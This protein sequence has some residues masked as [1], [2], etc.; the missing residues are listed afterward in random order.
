MLRQ[1]DTPR[2]KR[3]R[4]RGFRVRVL[5][6]LG[7]CAALG[8]LGAAPPTSSPADRQ[9]LIERGRYLTHDV[10]MCVQCHSPRDDR[11]Q[12][13]RSQEFRGAPIPVT[14]YFPEPWALRAPNIRGASAYP[15]ADLIRLLR[16]GIA[17]NGRSPQPPMPPFRMTREDAE[18]IT[19][20]LRSLD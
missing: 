17:T 8:A 2:P 10:A 1:N 6:L 5:S 19:A 13:I 12:I 4:R 16:E 14:A 15:E 11:G 18:A 3:A 20:Y 7:A 9:A